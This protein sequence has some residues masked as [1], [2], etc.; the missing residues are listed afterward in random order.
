MWLLL[1]FS[2]LSSFH[3]VFLPTTLASLL[4]GVTLLSYSI[5]SISIVVPRREIVLP[6]SKKHLKKARRSESDLTEA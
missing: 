4:L 6:T 5:L 2:L 1:K 3:L